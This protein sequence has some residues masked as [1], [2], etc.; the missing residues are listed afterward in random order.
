[1]IRSKT[2]PRNRVVAITASIA[3]G[4][5]SDSGVAASRAKGY[6]MVR[7]LLSGG[8]PRGPPVLPALYEAADRFAVAL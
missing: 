5:L 7:G 6:S 3:T 1:L 2:S 4:I 8:Y